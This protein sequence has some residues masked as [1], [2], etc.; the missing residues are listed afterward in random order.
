LTGL[1]LLAATA[2]AARPP[3]PAFTG[4]E[5]VAIAGLIDATTATLADG[6]ILRLAGIESPPAVTPGAK[7]A[8]ETLV[9]GKPLELRYAGA[10]S[11]RE[12]HVVAELYAGGRWIERALVS[13]GLARVR[14]SA[15]ERVG[16]AALLATEDRARRARRGLWR[17]RRFA[18]RPAEDAARD[19]GTWQIVEGDVVTARQ[20]EDG[21]FLAF[22]P[23]RTS[24]F[25]AH[26]PRA[27]LPLFRDAKL[28]LA[29]LQGMRLR[30]RGFIDGTRRPTI[31]VTFPEQ[32]ER[33]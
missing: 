21:A 3:V 29:T 27:A 17:E 18:V 6:R 16:L 15:D 14:G 22:G 26:V 4:H 2:V 11:D 20:S 19:A 12:G 8:L 31:E 13:R 23:D 32:I 5:S 7:A 30:V 25:T 28:D 24:A 9:A 1:L 10:A 33:P